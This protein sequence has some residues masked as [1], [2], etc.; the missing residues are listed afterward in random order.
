[1]PSTA[2]TC[3]LSVVIPTYNRCELTQQAIDSMLGQDTRWR[4]EI[5]VVIDGSTDDSERVLRERYADVERV[6]VIVA[7]RGGASAA[8]NIGFRAARGE[9]VC[10]LDSDDHWLPR[11]LAVFEQIFAMH[12]RLAFASID[13]STIPRRGETQITHLVAVDSPGWTHARFAQA[14]PP[15]ETIELHGVTPGSRFLRGDFFPPIILGDLFYLSG[16]VMRRDAAAA[17]GPFT[18]RFRYFNDWEFFARLC[19]QGAGA[20]LDYDGFRRDTGRPDQISR[21]RP[22][23]SM[24]R[25]H[26]YILRSLPR[27]FAERMAHYTPQSRLAL[28]DAHYMMGRALKQ[29]AHRR[30]ARRYLARCLRR[31]YKPARSLALLLATFLRK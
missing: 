9:F 2:N 12:P 1:M 23:T 5:I 29:T 7:P 11:T 16:M 22:V 10:F 28:D 4:V 31:G 20:Y 18:E 25:R 19:L 8:R 14:A 3:D 30:W 13:G 24:P 17:A 15:R 6:R 21:R 26:L 27:R